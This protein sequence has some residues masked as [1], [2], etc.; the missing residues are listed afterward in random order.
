MASEVVVPLEGDGVPALM[1][2]SIE[3]LLLFIVPHGM[4]EDVVLDRVPFKRHY[5]E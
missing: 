5:H 3:G 1:L 2:Q 4:R